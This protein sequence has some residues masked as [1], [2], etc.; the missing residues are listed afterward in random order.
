MNAF[1]L[2]FRCVGASLRSQMQYRASFLMMTLGHLAVTGIEI[3]GI[4]VLFDRFKGLQGWRLPEVAL[5]YGMVQ[6]SFALAEG[7]AR[8]FDTFPALVKS[9]DFDRLLLRPRSTA[10]QV[11][12]REAQ[13]MRLGRLTQGLAVLAWAVW[14]LGVEWTLAR[15]GLIVFAV[16]GGLCLFSGLFVLQATLS[17]WTTESLEVLN[18]VTYG[19]CETGQLP[20]SVYR[21]W[22]RR[23]FTFI[24]PLACV[25]YFPGLA[26]LGRRDEAM[27]SPAWFGWAAPLVG[28]AFLAAA[29]GVWSWGARRYRSS[30]S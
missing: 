22:F 13:L 29:L 25:T 17:F 16:A 19:G 2:Y 15:A 30:G 27:G 20:L 1:R 10:F 21:P 12:A 6:V 26:V 14:A 11:M 4:W 7:L 18:T 23:F 3:L 8:G 24:V 9:G 5:F 28:V